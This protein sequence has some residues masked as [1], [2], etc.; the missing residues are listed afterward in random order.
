M[1]QIDHYIKVKKTDLSFICVYLEAYEGM[2][3]IRTPNPKSGEETIVHMMVSPDFE[4]EFST[5]MNDL[6]A[7]VSWEE[8]EP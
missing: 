2:C 4:S 3:A 8:V 1:K 6:K 5:I 7:D